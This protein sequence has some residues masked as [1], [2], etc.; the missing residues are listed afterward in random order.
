MRDS[1]RE[2]VDFRVRLKPATDDREFEVCRRP[3]LPEPG[4]ALEVVRDSHPHR[5]VHRHRLEI[6]GVDPFHRGGLA[7]DGQLTAPP[8]DV[9]TIG[10][11]INLHVMINEGLGNVVRTEIWTSS[12]NG[13]SWRPTGAQFDGGL[14][15]LESQ[16]KP[17]TDGLT[18]RCTSKFPCGSSQAAHRTGRPRTSRRLPTRGK[19]RRA[20][21]PGPNSATRAT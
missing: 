12:D 14:R 15:L 19:L 9:I 3:L 10:Q 20:F 7:R 8:S 1:Y 6:G 5:V 21:Q 17:L 18:A 16:W 11:D 13:K 4:P 2:I